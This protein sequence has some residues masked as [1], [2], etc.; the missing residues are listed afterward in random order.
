[1]R[2]ISFS[3]LSALFFGAAACQNSSADND[4]AGEIS[5][6]DDK[7]SISWGLFD[8]QLE[9]T[10]IYNR[11]RV[12][13]LANIHPRLCSNKR[14][15]LA[16]VRRNGLDLAL[17]SDEMQNDPEVVLAAV[18]QNGMALQYASRELRE[19]Q[20]IVLAAVQQNGLALQYAYRDISR[21]RERYIEVALAAVQENWKSFDLVDD[22]YKGNAE[23]ALA[24]ITQ[25]ATAIYLVSP[26]LFSNQEFVRS[27]YNLSFGAYYYIYQSMLEV[28]YTSHLPQDL[29][30]SLQSTLADLAAL[31]IDF[32]D[33]FTNVTPAEVDEIVASRVVLQQEGSF[34]DSSPVALVVLP[35]SDRLNTFVHNN[36][37]QL[38]RHGYRVV[39][40]EAESDLE[41]Y[42]TIELT[43][44]RQP[45]SLLY[46]GGHGTATT[47]R[48]SGY[49]DEHD[50]SL[51]LDPSDEAEMYYLNSYL[52]ENSQVLL[53]SCHACY[54]ELQAMFE[55]V[56]PDSN[57]FVP[58]GTPEGFAFIFNDQNMV[59]DIDFFTS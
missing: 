11:I 44:Q 1:M 40:F 53:Y 51:L 49:P 35:K 57:F 54:G 16:A 23:I 58:D 15:V 9:E 21:F 27:C 12:G 10:E 30:A 36:I 20:E 3:I 37:S 25:D 33:R 42:E 5:Q 39:Y 38:I 52:A 59:I 45:I 14:L 43:G 46:L 4:T 28:A 6:A 41:V 13:G 56:F 22:Y 7:N 29:N 50:E 24:A 55:R 2:G 26:I 47:T 32:I 17:A 34:S 48:L 18:R 31:N 19:N 8:N